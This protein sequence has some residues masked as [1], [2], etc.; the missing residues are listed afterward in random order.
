MSDFYLNLSNF[1]Q[2]V[3]KLKEFRG[4]VQR[5]INASAT[6]YAATPMLASAKQKAPVKTGTLKRSLIK[7]T[8][9]Y[10]HAGVVMTL[11]GVDKDAEAIVNGRLLRPVKY[12]HLVE[13]G[14]RD[15]AAKP[16]MRPA[17]WTNHMAATSRFVQKLR[18][19]VRKEI[20]RLSTIGKQP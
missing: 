9:K 10:H 5:R 8:R 14:T 1:G 3:T 19:G 17:F 13:R 20:D 16:F 12:A 7:V 6:N 4:S 18:F 11:V 15:T 2:T